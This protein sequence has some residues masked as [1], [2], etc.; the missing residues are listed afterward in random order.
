MK[1]H[2]MRIF[3]V[4][5]E[6]GSHSDKYLE[7]YWNLHNLSVIP[8]F[9]SHLYWLII[10]SFS[11][12]E[13]EIDIPSY[14][15]TYLDILFLV[16]ILCKLLLVIENLKWNQLFLENMAMTSKEFGSWHFDNQK[17]E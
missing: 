16:I 6:L 17:L 12:I 4:K 9:P 10:A 7:S 14:F 13:W 2:A 1:S 3:L 11:P 15:E 8:N 5:S